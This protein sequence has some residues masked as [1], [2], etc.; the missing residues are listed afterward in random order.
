MLDCATFAS[1]LHMKGP[2]FV[3]R[4]T[5]CTKVIW[6]IEFQVEEVPVCDISERLRGNII[7]FQEKN[8]HRS[9]RVLGG[10]R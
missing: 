5:E 1:L 2:D 3:A 8:I 6:N 7:W 10:K 9:E 4:R